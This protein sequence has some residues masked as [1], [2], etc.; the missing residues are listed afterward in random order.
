[1]V[2]FAWIILTFNIMIFVLTMSILVANIIYVKSSKKDKSEY[3]DLEKIDELNNLLHIK[4]SSDNVETDFQLD[5]IISSVKILIEEYNELAKKCK[6]LIFG[7]QEQFKEFNDLKDINAKLLNE[8]TLLKEREQIIYNR[9]YQILKIEEDEQARMA[10]INEL[11]RL[12]QAVRALKAIEL[13]CDNI[14]NYFDYEALN[15]QVNRIKNELI[16]Y[17]KN[18]ENT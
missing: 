5:A 9:F 8:N 4:K 10:L 17:R 16:I 14:D 11:N 12:R 18:Q 13:I 1:M 15:G 7:G 2:T 3:V 6:T